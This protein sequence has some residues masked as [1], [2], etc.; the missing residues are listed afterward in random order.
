MHLGLSLSLS[1]HLHGHSRVCSLFTLILFCYFLLYLPPLFLFLNY[2]KSVVNL[3]DS[4]LFSDKVSSSDPD[5]DDATLEDMLHQVHRAQVYDSSREDLSVGLSTSSV[6]IEQGDML[7]I[8]RGDPV[9]TEAHKRR[10]GLFSTIKKSKFL[11]NAKQELVNTNF[12][13]LTTEEE[14]RLLQE[15]LLQQNL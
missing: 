12:K 7:K 1:Y 6:S 3:H 4:P 14:Q 13:P 11:Q 5:Y 9:S 15:Q 2:M 10:L 8:D